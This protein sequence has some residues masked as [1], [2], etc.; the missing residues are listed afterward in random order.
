MY[1]DLRFLSCYLLLCG[2]IFNFL[3]KIHFHKINKNS[4]IKFTFYRFNRLRLYIGVFPFNLFFLKNL[5]LTACFLLFDGA[6]I[7]FFWKIDIH[8]INKQLMILLIFFLINN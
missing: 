2:Q 5:F 7:C 6:N 8:K 3:N 1:I 4:K